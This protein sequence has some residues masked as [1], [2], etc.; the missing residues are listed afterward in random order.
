MK[1]KWLSILLVFFCLCG[2]GIAP[3]AIPQVSEEPAVAVCETE[4]AG[5][6]RPESHLQQLTGGALK[7]FPLGTT[8]ATAIGFF[9]EDLL[10]RRQDSLVLL[11][12]E[13]RYISTTHL[14]PPSADKVQ[15]LDSGIA[16]RDSRGIVLLDSDLEETGLISLPADLT[17]SPILSDDGKSLFYSTSSGIRV[18]E[19]D[20]G[21]ERLLRQSHSPQLLAG[22]HWGG[23]VLECEAGAQRIYLSAVD[24]RLL[25]DLPGTAS[26]TTAKD[27]YCCVRTDDGY[28]EI[29][30][31]SDPQ[32]PFLL[33]TDMLTP[34]VF[35]LP[36]IRAALLAFCHPKTGATVL[37]F[38]D[39]ETGAHL[40]S[41]TLPG[42]IPP[43]NVLADPAENS[44][45]FLLPDEETGNQN[46]CR[47]DLPPSTDSQSRL[48]PYQD[49]D[50]AE[51]QKC[52]LLA[53]QLA[54]KHGIQLLLGD[55]ATASQPWD[56]QFE[57]EN[58][59]P[60]IRCRLAQL[61]EA[62]SRYPLDFLRQAVADK[63][64]TVCLVR[65]ITGQTDAN[66]PAQA[67]GVQYWDDTG[68]PRLVLS[69]QEDPEPT[70]HHELFH[71]FE[72]RVFSACNAYDTWHL[73]NP[74]GFSYDYNYTD[75]PGR[76]SPLLS[77]ET[78]AFI[79]SY[80]MSFPRED[81]ARIMEYAMQPNRADCFSS[82]TMQRKLR[83]LCIGLQEAF[84]L[85]QYPEILP[86]EQ[87]LTEPL[88]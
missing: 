47:W 58:R 1:F 76:D 66:T 75:Y 64:I 37:T 61:D 46:L 16:Y 69:S 55:E 57:S 4:P 35:P 63:E 32:E 21:L 18:L 52:L 27:F 48:K 41:L 29:L 43:T 15:L 72:S 44:I 38:Y 59:A 82:N 5:L 51:F 54:K 19:V 26:V 30:C 88:T 53:D 80:S 49:Q 81:R 20:S 79:D 33:E 70:V 10:I 67:A 8:E 73:L 45:W 23:T 24:G 28:T 22:I 42:S 14:L 12:G 83:T 9:G 11:S 68:H 17:A 84:G 2:C 87:Y 6:Y 85:A 13:N 36:D 34:S 74:T 50:P 31:G 86:W 71:I 3:S 7:V 77:G 56:Y 40:S 65:S 60:V 78:R 62:L 25:H 39:L